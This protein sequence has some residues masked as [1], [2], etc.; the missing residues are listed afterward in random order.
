[1]I[2]GRLKIL[3]ISNY[4]PYPPDT[5]T[6]MRSLNFLKYFAKKGELTL[7]APGDPAADTKHISELKNY[8][9]NV[10]LMD[11]KTYGP[12]STIDKKFSFSERMNQLIKMEPWSLQDFVS[13]DFRQ[14]LLSLNLDQFD[15]IFIRYVQPAYYFLTDSKLKPLLKKTVIDVDDI[16]MNMQERRI[17]GMNFGYGKLRNILDFIFLKNYYRKIK[18][19]RACFVTNLKDKEFLLEQ[20]FSKNMFIIPN[21]IEVNG[22]RNAQNV[23][24]SSEI[25]FCGTLSF[26]HNEEAAVYFCSEVFQKIKKEIPNAHLSIV[27][28]NPTKKVLGLSSI[29]GVSVVGSVPSMEPY[30]EKTAIVVVPLLNGAGTR[31]KILEAMSYQKAVVSTSVGAEGLDV[32]DGENIYVADGPDLFANRCVG[33]L[34][35]SE[36]RISLGRKGYELVKAQYDTSAFDKKMDEFFNSFQQVE[37]CQK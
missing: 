37:L 2:T 14:K 29:P 19:A 30:Y 31:I 26:P 22:V 5:G 34:K 17:K 8:C 6:K 12:N 15:L 21:T 20:G 10:V 18:V 3:F 32:T 25:L 11:S 27:G 36:K 28:K 9:A 35:D 1:M 7:I 16:S 33:L 23:V 4:L 13:Q 24:Q